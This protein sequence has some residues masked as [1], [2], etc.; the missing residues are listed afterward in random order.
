MHYAK[1]ASK[2]REQIIQ[3]SGE[4][5]STWGKVVRRFLTEAIYGIQ[6]RQSVRLT[7]IARALGE[8]IPIK[9]TQYRLCR[10]LGREGLGPRVMDKICRMGAS[11]VEKKTLLVLDI[12]DITKKYARKMEYM[13]RVR[14]GSQKCLG[15]GYWTLSVIATDVG[16]PPL[17]P[18]YNHLYSHKSPDYESENTEIRRA[19]RR[20][21]KH[22]RK[23]GVWVLDRGGD[24]GKVFAEMITRELS[25]IIR[26]KKTRDLIYRRGEHLVEELASACPMIHAERIVRQERGKETI[27]DLEFGALPVHLPGQ[28]IPVTLVVVRGF[29]QEPMALL[30]SLRVTRGRKSLWWVISAYLTR[31]RIEET[32]RFM[33]QSYQVEDIRL[34]T[35]IR[36]QNMM[37]ILLAVAYFAMVYLGLRIKLRVL[38]GHVLKAA[39][40]LFGVP[41]FQFYALADGIR[42]LLFGRHKGLESIN[43]LPHPQK[44]QL[45]LFDP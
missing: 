39:R 8:K 9:K 42:E 32:I 31:W 22:T 33:K 17:V 10:Q 27:Y 13:A 23:R 40:R 2:L 28:D 25:F 29:G 3:F 14:D 36:L 34:L 4:L 19:I 1:T 21:I 45:N 26:L 35:Y 24:R 16:K 43:P 6:A 20:V 11:S 44:H 15:N 38:A 5:S 30:T 7:E 18:L 41:D 12:S 37:A